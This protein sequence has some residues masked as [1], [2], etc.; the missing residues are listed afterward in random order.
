MPPFPGTPFPQSFLELHIIILKNKLLKSEI[1][2]GLHELIVNYKELHYTLIRDW[3]VV[4]KQ[5]AES[6]YIGNLSTWPCLET[7]SL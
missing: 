1:I 3:L 7:K 6:P 4:P 5:R 2:L